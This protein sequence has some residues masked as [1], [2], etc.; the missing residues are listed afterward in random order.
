MLVRAATYE[1]HAARLVLGGSG[2]IKRHNAHGHCSCLKQRRFPS[3]SIPL[4]C[5]ARSFLRVDVDTPRIRSDLV[6][7]VASVLCSRSRARRGQLQLR[8]SPRAE[9]L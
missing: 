8:R 9:L 2:I 1:F 5:G 4:A 6:H 7:G 3:P